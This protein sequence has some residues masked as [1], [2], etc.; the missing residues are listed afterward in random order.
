MTLSNDTSDDEFMYN[1]LTDAIGSHRTLYNLGLK[2]PRRFGMNGFFYGGYVDHK[3]NWYFTCDHSVSYF[4]SN[5][6]LIFRIPTIKTKLIY[7][8]VTYT[9]AAN[10]ETWFLLFTRTNIK[11]IYIYMFTNNIQNIH[12]HIFGF[13]LKLFLRIRIRAIGTYSIFFM[14]YTYIYL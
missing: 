1:I 6:T 9:A 14:V 3:T 12:P 13:L 7:F 2:F 11:L 8:S 4:I 10:R 5:F